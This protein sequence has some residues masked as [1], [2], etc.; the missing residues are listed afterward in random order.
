[1]IVS[2]RRIDK[3]GVQR[4]QSTCQK[5]NRSVHRTTFYMQTCRVRTRMQSKA[6]LS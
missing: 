4:P 6:T 1:L 3:N 2:G 5:R